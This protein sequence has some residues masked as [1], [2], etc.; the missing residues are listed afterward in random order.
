M[1]PY[2]VYECRHSRG[3]REDEES[4]REECEITILVI[5]SD[6]HRSHVK[7]FAELGDLDNEKPFYDRLFKKLYLFTNEFAISYLIEMKL[8]PLDR[9]DVISG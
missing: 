3:D 7:D 2:L 9:L 6:C 5:R 1:G 8:K 4:R